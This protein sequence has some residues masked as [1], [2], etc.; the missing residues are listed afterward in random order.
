[1]T[2]LD[3]SS[4][5][6]STLKD[7]DFDEL[8]ALTRLTLEDNSL[9]DLPADIFS[10]LPSL[11]RLD[12][13]DNS[14]S[15]LPSVFAD[16][17]SLILLDLDGN[18]LSSLP[19]GVFS[20]Q[21]A[22]KTLWLARN[23]FSTLP[24]NAFSDV[25][26]VT[27]LDLEDNDLADLSGSAFADLSDLLALWLPGNE[28]SS[29]P[30]GLLS[31]LT[32]LESLDLDG[33]S[34]DP[35]PIRVT[36]ELSGSQ[37]QASIPAG[38]PFET[39]VPVQVTNGTLA[40]GVTGVTV[41]QGDTES[42]AVAVQRASGTTAAVTADIGRL[43]EPP[44]DDFGYALVR[45]DDLPLEV[46]AGTR[47]IVLHP[48]SLT[49]EEGGSNGYQVVLQ[50]RPSA[51]VSLAVTTPTG[52][53]ANPDPLTFKTDDWNTPQTV[54][55]TA[56]TDADTSNNAVTV[57]HQA[58][59]GDYAGMTA[60]LD[61]TIAETVTDTNAN[62]IITSDAAFAVQEHETTVG[63]VVATDGDVEDSVTGFTLGG[64][65]GD[66]LQDH[67][68]RAPCPFAAPPDF[69]KPEDVRSSSPANDADNN[70]YVVAVNRGERRRTRAGV[71]R[72]R[73]S[74]VTVQD[75]E[76][77]A[78]AAADANGHRR[79][80]EHVACL[81]SRG[82]AADPQHRAPRSTTTTCRSARRTWARS[83][84]AGHTT[85]ARL[86]LALVVDLDPGITYEVQVRAAQRRSGAG[87]WSPSGEATTADQQSGPQLL[88]RAPCP[89][90]VTL[91][92][93]AAPH[94]RSACRARSP[95][96]D[97]EFV[98]L[99]ASSR[100]EAVATAS[101]EGP[102]V[103]VRPLAAGTGDH[104]GDGA[105]SAGSRP[106]KARSQVTVEAPTRSDPTASID[107]AGD[108]LTLEFTDS[109]ALDERRSYEVRVRQ[110]APVSGWA[111]FCFKRCATPP[112][113]PAIETRIGGSFP[114]DP[115]AERGITYEV[116]L[117]PCRRHRAPTPRPADGPG[118]PR[119]PPPVRAASTSTWW[120]WAPPPP[121]TAARCS[122]RPIRGSGS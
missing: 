109:F 93:P 110:K 5:S 103:V 71:R 9:S 118:L 64:A 4:S 99:E 74:L 50:A 63:T 120:W 49:V 19:S 111:T 30:D 85:A 76:R 86:L 51:E 89:F 53:T 83:T 28:L 106:P 29:L 59:G 42:A 23:T 34:V 77:T 2:A 108:T 22:L 107:S 122:Q 87:P 91:P 13:E 104:R 105:R 6:V 57:T 67:A 27:W 1:M 88:S 26:T 43:P 62:P 40:G 94:R 113:P 25:P 119:R 78:R 38:A 69:E 31:G 41:S 79:V 37:V 18:Q 101:M 80:F 70:E 8:P 115:S 11:V 56:G 15:T 73:R 54:T 55:L 92:P 24:A 75:L 81:V 44:G 58:T 84:G 65:D 82:P 98:W 39:F 60:S 95:D 47:G 17:S 36:L 16:L 21:T 100:N 48:G 90:G 102:A 116:H 32:A 96:P 3:V 68:R 114:S 35:L 20:G 33:N 66:L 112:A 45:S 7:G 14:F 117:P 10:G 72:R 46:I 121:P 12:L 97:N 52:L 61:V